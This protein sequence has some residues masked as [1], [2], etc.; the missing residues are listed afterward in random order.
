MATCVVLKTY[1][2]SHISKSIPDY[3]MTRPQVALND[4]AIDFK[5]VFLLTAFYVTESLTSLL[6]QHVAEVLLSN[7]ALIYQIP[8]K[9]PVGA[10]YVA[11]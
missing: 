5:L 9:N 6:L 4:R 2:F 11:K 1:K 10:Y 7:Y 3:T 8:G